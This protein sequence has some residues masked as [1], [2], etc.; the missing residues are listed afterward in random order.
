[1]DKKLFKNVNKDIQKNINKALKTFKTKN[2]GYKTSFVQYGDV[3]KVLFPDGLSLKTE[4]DF[5]RMGLLN[6]I[7]SKIIRYANSWENK[8]H[9]A[10]SLHDLGVYSF[11]AQTVEE[12][13]LLEQKNKKERD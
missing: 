4:E 1:M 6:M 12:Q 3:M 9:T 7:V 5:V 10:D 11:M 13:I 8:Y 2:K